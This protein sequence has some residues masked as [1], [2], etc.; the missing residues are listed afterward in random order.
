MSQALQARRLFREHA[1][2]YQRASRQWGEVAVLQPVASKLI[3]WFLVAV[4]VAILLFLSLADY[5]RKETVQG[6]LTPTAGT[7]K[8]FATT[9]GVIAAVYVKEGEDVAQGRPL[10]SI[11]TPQIASDGQD[12]NAAMLAALSLQRDTLRQQIA[13]EEQRVAS[14]R[15]RLTAVSRGLDAAAAQLRA[16]ISIQGERIRLAESLVSSSSELVGKGYMS[17]VEYKQ[18]QAAVLEQKQALNTLARQL[19]GLD[20]DRTETRAKLD[21]LPTVMSEKIETMRGELSNTEQRIAQSHGR[22]AY[23]IRAAIAGRVSTLQ[24]KTGQY[25]DPHQLQLEI[26]PANSRLQAELFVPTRAAGFVKPG[27]RVRI[28]YDAFP[29]QNFG[30]YGGTIVNVSRTIVTGQ[31]SGGPIELKEPA[32]RATVA[33]ERADI[34]VHDER[35]PLQ[36]DMSL[37]ADIILERRSLGHWLLAPLL[38]AAR[39]L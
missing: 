24:A 7:A 3:T 17:Q 27:Q 35:V 20:N 39:Q 11:A 32:Y 16:Q 9:P 10:L 29:Y 6:Y 15:D 30:T 28:L 25:A 26:V 19:S 1:L 23:V 34:D 38:S 13:S 33:L 2:E 18:R 8:V 21:Q 4:F 31:S 12:I 37:R 22:Q 14:E 36:A 5:A